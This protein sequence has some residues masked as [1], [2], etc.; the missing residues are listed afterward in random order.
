VGVAV[1]RKIAA[2]GR[3][4]VI[5]L[6]VF[7]VASGQL[8]TGG[9]IAAAV[10]FT[11]A[12]YAALRHSF[13]SA[14]L[15]IWNLG[16]AAA[17]AVGTAGG[18]ILAL[19]LN[20]FVPG[21]GMAVPQLLQMA[22]AV[23]VLSAA[24]ESIA[25]SSAAGRQR[26][27]VVGVADGGSELIEELSMA[28]RSRFDVVGVVDDER[29]SDQVAGAPLHGRVDELARIVEEHRPDVVV[30]ANDRCRPRAFSE[31]LG[32]ANLGFSV[33]GLAEF[34]EY[35]FGRL[36]VRHL[37][38][39]WFMSVL[40]LYHRRYNQI[41][42]RIFDVVV[43]SIGL[44]LTAP[45]LPVLA[46]LVK[47]SS[48]GPVIFKQNR[49]GENGRTIKVF[50]FRTMRN[51]V[52]VSNIA[53]LT[54]D[55]DPRITR[56]GSVMRRR[57]LDELP[58]LLNVLKGDMSIVGPRPEPDFAQDTSEDVPH[59]VRRRLVK[60]GITGWAQIHLGYTGC[61]YEGVSRKLS[62]DLWYLRHRSLVV[63]LA[64]CAKTFSTLLSGSGAR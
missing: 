48:P 54:E 14:Q 29:D 32:V 40:H 4:G 19:A 8:S 57:R 2:A 46:L 15:T 42:K 27:L 58:Q 13:L 59:W 53:S 20:A 55:D 23:L 51:D 11:A 41:A 21:L 44:L 6:P 64:I 34:Y 17:A 25:I 62:Y 50:K 36:P 60:P 39:R 56:V 31:L 35:A 16:T 9:A 28:P 22:V 5:W 18:L 49:P 61:D 63:D 33:V 52:D 26:V 30:L 38:E 37:D 3:V 12:W 47:R 7:T 45:L 43:A 24:W 1:A 10:V